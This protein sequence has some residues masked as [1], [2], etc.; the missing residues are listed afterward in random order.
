MV[1]AT[2][3]KAQW[4][5]QLSPFSQ[6]NSMISKSYSHLLQLIQKHPHYACRSWESGLNIYTTKSHTV[7][8]SDQALCISQIFTQ[9]SFFAEV[10]TQNRFDQGYSYSSMCPSYSFISKTM[11]ISARFRVGLTFCS[12]ETKSKGC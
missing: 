11:N 1:P 12:S 8:K 7:R 4:R 9:Q 10:T 5:C 6:F 3:R 2:P